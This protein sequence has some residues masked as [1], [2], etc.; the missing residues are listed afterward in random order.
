M[1]LATLVRVH[2]GFSEVMAREARAMSERDDNGCEELEAFI[3]E[4]KRRTDA[5]G[6]LWK[7]FMD[8]AR[9]GDGQEYEE[10]AHAFRG[11]FEEADASLDGLR[12][13]VRRFHEATGKLPGNADLVEQTARTL[14]ELKAKIVPELDWFTRPPPE[15]DPALLEQSEAEGGAIDIRDIIR[16]LQGYDS[17]DGSPADR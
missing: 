5:I 1:S 4:E 9:D 12:Q 2:R 7:W 14:E 3:A 8:N 16:E 15:I 6:E 17:P 13:W 11:L 10:F